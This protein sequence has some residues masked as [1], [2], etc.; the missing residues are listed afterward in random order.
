MNSRSSSQSMESTT[1]LRSLGL[2]MELPPGQPSLE[3]RKG[4]EGDRRCLGKTNLPSFDAAWRPFALACAQ[5]TPASSVLE[6]TLIRKATTVKLPR[7]CVRD[8]SPR[9]WVGDAW[10]RH[11]RSRLG[12]IVRRSRAWRPF[13]RL[14]TIVTTKSMVQMMQINDNP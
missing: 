8:A 10:A 5:R 14:A 11:E 2:L 6:M 3:W 7:R 4:R 12:S 1:L 13:R 9:H